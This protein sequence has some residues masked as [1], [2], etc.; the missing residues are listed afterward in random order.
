MAKSP[1]SKNPPNGWDFW[2]S[3]YPLRPDVHVQES[4]TATDLNGNV[5]LDAAGE[6]WVELPEWFEALNRDF[7]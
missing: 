7:R 1:T 6:A 2:Q 4:V 5:V 3:M